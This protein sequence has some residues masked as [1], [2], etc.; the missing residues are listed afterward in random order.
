MMHIIVFLLH[1][2]FVQR[3]G[4]GMGIVLHCIGSESCLFT[5]TGL[6]YMS[7]TSS[8]GLHIWI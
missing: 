3:M 2:R 7:A 6:V 4:M 1:C 5:F 8:F